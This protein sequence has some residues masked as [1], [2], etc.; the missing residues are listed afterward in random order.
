MLKNYG[1]YELAYYTDKCG[2]RYSLCFAPAT[3]FESPCNAFMGSTQV[4]ECLS[5]EG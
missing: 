4:H 3:Q 5:Q 1:K 2:S